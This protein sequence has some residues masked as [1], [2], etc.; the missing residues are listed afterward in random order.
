MEC[1]ICYELL[2]N[3]IIK[4]NC[5]HT[6]HKEC[7]N[8]WL[9][10]RQTCPYCNQKLRIE[11]QYGKGEIFFL[12]LF[13]T[14]LLIFVY[15]LLIMLLSLVLLIIAYILVLIYNNPFITLTKLSIFIYIYIR[16]IP[17]IYIT[18]IYGILNKLQVNEKNRSKNNSR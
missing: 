18:N 16:V 11:Y 3:E 4:T 6:F 1:S 13:I 5:N 15:M 9:K 7:L 2:N 17:Y 12:H 14:L 8:K 10:I